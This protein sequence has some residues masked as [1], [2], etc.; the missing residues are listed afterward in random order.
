MT[1]DELTRTLRAFEEELHRPEVRRD[2]SRLRALL[3]ADFEEIGRSGRR[4]TRDDMLRELPSGNDVGVLR[5]D[6]YAVSTIGDGVALMTY[7]SA[8]VDASGNRVRVT[9][10]ASI[11]V[12]TA[13]GWQMRFHQGTPM[14]TR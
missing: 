13:A 4:Y 9:L 6:N 3:H 8:Y 10:R 7:R 1:A 12:A 11:W 14:E 5:A 2:S